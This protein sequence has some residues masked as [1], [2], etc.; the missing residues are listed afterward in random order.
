MCACVVGGW[1]Y[2]GKRFITEVSM[3]SKHNNKHTFSFSGKG[4]TG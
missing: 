3:R 4:R 2:R 1:R